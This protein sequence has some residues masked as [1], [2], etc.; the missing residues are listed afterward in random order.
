MMLFKRPFNPFK[1]FNGF[2]NTGFCNINFLKTSGK[3]TIFF[4][5]TAIFLISC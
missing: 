5:N 2:I 3:R 1:N 4:K